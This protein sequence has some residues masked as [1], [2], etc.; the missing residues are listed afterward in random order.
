MHYVLMDKIEN[1]SRGG[2]LSTPPPGI[3]M[4]QLYK[5]NPGVLDVFYM[6]YTNRWILAMQEFWPSCTFQR[7]DWVSKQGIQCNL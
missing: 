5:K 4:I 6:L 7:Y 3:S 1:V 2:V